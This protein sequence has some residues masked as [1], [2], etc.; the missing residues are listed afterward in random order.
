MEGLP[1]HLSGWVDHAQTYHSRWAMNRALFN[2]G[3]TQKN[4]QEKPRWNP[5]AQNKKRYERDPDAMDVDQAQLKPLTSQDR[6]E[7]MKAGKC[8]RCRRQG[9]CPET[10]PT[11]KAPPSTQKPQTTKEKKTRPKS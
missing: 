9:I 4:K 8:F 1:I 11:T 3:G 6:E 2:L 10:A 7:L 5:K